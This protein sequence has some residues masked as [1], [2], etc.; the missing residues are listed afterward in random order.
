MFADCELVKFDDAIKI[1]I[2]VNAMKEKLN[3]MERNQTWEL[4]NLP[5]GK[6][7]IDVKWV[8]K[9]KLKPTGKV[10]KYKAVLIAK[11]FL[12]KLGLEYQEAFS[13][14]ARLEIV[15]LVI[16]LAAY[17]TWQLHQMDVKLAFLNG[18]LN[19]EVFLN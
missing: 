4:V 12:Q 13:P 17:K 11:G 2:W 16:A 14:V 7:A 18:P 6:K 19:E 1:D 9:V 5:K 10:E 8:Y 3:V 15:R